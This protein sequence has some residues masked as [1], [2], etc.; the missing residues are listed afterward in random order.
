GESADGTNPQIGKPRW[1]RQQK[2]RDPDQH[3]PE[4]AGVAMPPPQQLT[5]TALGIQVRA[6]LIFNERAEKY[7]AGNHWF[8]SLTQ[9][10]RSKNCCAAVSDATLSIDVEYRKHVTAYV[11]QVIDA[12]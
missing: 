12:S 4:D 6:L 7:F 5:P 2:S 1:G 8:N 9:D 10:G 3:G 11:S